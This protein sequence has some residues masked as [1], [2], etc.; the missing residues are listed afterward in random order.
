MEFRHG[1][2]EQS[3]KEVGLITLRAEKE[4]S[5]TLMEIFIK[6]NGRTAKLMAMECIVTNVEESMKVI[7]SKICKKATERKYGTITAVTM[8]IS[9]LE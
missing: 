3:T 2:T 6:V 7:G 9:D 1:L 8:V 4:D 5:Y